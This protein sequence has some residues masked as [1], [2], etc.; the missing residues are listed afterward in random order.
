MS[1]GEAMVEEDFYVFDSGGVDII[2]GVEWL[3]KLGEVMINWREM[4]MVYNL[5]RKRGIKG[6]LHCRDS[7]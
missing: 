4:T 5:E 7:W 6:T 2:L 3:A 1:L